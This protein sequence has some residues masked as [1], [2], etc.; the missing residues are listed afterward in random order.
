MQRLELV[1]G[2]DG[3]Y[4]RW[5]RQNHEGCLTESAVCPGVAIEC[6]CS[7]G[8][9]LREVVSRGLLDGWLWSTLK[10]VA[11][12]HRTHQHVG[13]IRTCKC[14][15]VYTFN[16]TWHSLWCIYKTFFSVL[17]QLAHN[18]QTLGREA[19]EFRS[20]GSGRRIC[21]KFVCHHR[22]GFIVGSHRLVLEGNY[23]W[24]VSC[25]KKPV[26]QTSRYEIQTCGSVCVTCLFLGGAVCSSRR[27]QSVCWPVPL[28]RLGGSWYSEILW[29]F[30][31]NMNRGC[32]V[33]PSWAAVQS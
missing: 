4:M 26:H 18:W 31:G 10:V 23:L 28:Q 20:C 32:P 5:G 1:T 13:H 15:P 12:L 17:F 30:W 9:E 6:D 25:H 22:H 33:K 24:W 29:S 19:N 3:V 16:K 8:Q 2:S 7:L 11:K 21:F 27:L 14:P